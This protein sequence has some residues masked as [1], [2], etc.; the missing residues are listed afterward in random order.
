MRVILIELEVEVPV[1]DPKAGELRLWAP[2]EQ[3]EAERL[4]EG[5]ACAH[6]D[7]HQRHRADAVDRISRL[8]HCGSACH[9][10]TG[11]GSATVSS[12]AMLVSAINRAATARSSACAPHR[13]G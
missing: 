5:D 3:V 1:S 13:R 10:K 4:V 9:A 12:A 6:L 7:R 2:V 8:L 11:L